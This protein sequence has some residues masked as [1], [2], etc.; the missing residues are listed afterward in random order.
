M[1]RNF[2]LAGAI[3]VACAL[4]AGCASKSPKGVAEV[5]ECRAAANSAP[6]LSFD[7]G[8]DYLQ[9]QADTYSE[10]MTAHGYVLDDAA[11]ESNLDHFEMVQNSNVMMGDPAPLLAKRRQ[12]LRMNPEFWR[13]AAPPSA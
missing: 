13:P 7:V 11:V 10:C 8:I 9:R 1:L 3:I 5:H 12:K 6:K 4:A 2:G